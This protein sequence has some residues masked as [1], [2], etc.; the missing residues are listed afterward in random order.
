MKCPVLSLKKKKQHLI[1]AVSRTIGE[2]EGGSL[3]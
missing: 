1:N 2:D 3:G